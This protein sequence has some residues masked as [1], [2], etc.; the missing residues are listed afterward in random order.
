M[1][2]MYEVSNMNFIQQ[3]LT[4]YVHHWVCNLPAAGTN[5]DSHYGTISQSYQPANIVAGWSH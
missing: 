2:V 1:E 3:G 5:T 4:G